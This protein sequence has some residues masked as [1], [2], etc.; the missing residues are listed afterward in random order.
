M[1]ALVPVRGVLA[2]SVAVTVWT[3]PARVLVVKLTVA[4]PLALVRLVPEAKLPPAPVFVQVTVSPALET[5]LLLA[6]ASWALIVTALPATGLRS[7]EHTSEL[8]SSLQI[9]CRLAL[10]PVRAVLA[11][12]F[13]VSLHDALPI[14]LVVKLTVAMPLALVRL[15][16]EAKLPPAPVFVQVTVSPAL[17]TGLLLASASWALIVTALPATGL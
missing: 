5:G 2:S 4:M 10:V 9:V 12:S 8:Q 15:V 13:A 3:V 11:S 16:P 7:E 1:L 6:S 17:E 14:L